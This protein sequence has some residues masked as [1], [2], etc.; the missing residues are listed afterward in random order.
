MKPIKAHLTLL[1]FLYL[2]TQTSCFG[3]YGHM[4]IAQIAKNQLLQNS[5]NEAYEFAEK[6]TSVLDPFSEDVKGFIQTSCWADKSTFE[7]NFGILFN[8]HF[9]NSKPV[10][11]DESFN[12]EREK[13]SD[14]ANSYNLIKHSNTTLSSW[15]A[16]DKIETQME[17]SFSLRMV[18]HV[19]GDIHQPFHNCHSTEMEPKGDLG[20]NLFKLKVKDTF[21]DNLHKLWDAFMYGI[22]QT[23]I[24]DLPASDNEIKQT[25]FYANKLMK[26]Y[27]R[28]SLPEVSI[29]DQ[30]IWIKEGWELCK[31]VGYKNIEYNKEITLD[32]DY[33]KSNLPR[34]ERR[35][36]LAGYRLSNLLINFY[37]A[38]RNRSINDIKFLNK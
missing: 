6:L 1:F 22:E 18:A 2:I 36:A 7:K 29:T 13:I 23:Y 35:M 38:Y 4:I 34:I 8:F 30:E 3:C 32:N 12:I 5:N 15:K 28:E 19:I 33:I 16:N 10:N 31:A 27:P 11:T 25:E 17:K 20:G 14:M 26:E 21:I 37:E 24:M 9:L